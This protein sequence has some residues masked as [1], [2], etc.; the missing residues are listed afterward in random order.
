MRV[1][2]LVDGGLILRLDFFELQPH[3]VAAIAPG[4]PPFGVD[5][6]LRAGQA[7]SEAC[8]R[9]VLERAGGTDGDASAAD[10]QRQRCRDGVTE[11]VGDGNAEYDARAS[12]AIE[13]VGK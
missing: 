3:A 6:A 7:K 10:V 13:V 11:P 9:A 12:A 5:V 4:D 1:D 8:A 2:E